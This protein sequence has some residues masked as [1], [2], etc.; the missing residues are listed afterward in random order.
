MQDNINHL[1]SLIPEDYEKRNELVRRLEAVEQS[2]NTWMDVVNVFAEVVG[3]EPMIAAY[4]S[5]K[6][7]WM[8]DV[9]VYWQQ[10]DGQK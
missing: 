6:K 1:I 2:D 4:T 8:K 5:K 7:S 10:F 3:T 9:Q